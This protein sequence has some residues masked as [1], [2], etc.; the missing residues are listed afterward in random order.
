MI[1]S[2][3]CAVSISRACSQG[4]VNP[5]AGREPFQQ[6]RIQPLTPTAAFAPGE[7]AIELGYLHGYANTHACI[8]AL[9]HD[10]AM[11]R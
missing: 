7:R 3:R 11:T 4:C 6:H 5:V 10:K 2:A 1:S 9:L 8:V